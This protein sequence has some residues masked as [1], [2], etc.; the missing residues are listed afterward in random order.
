[1]DPWHMSAAIAPASVYDVAHSTVVSSDP[2]AV[3][4]GGGF[5]TWIVADEALFGAGFGSAVADVTFADATIAEPFA[6]AQSPSN[7]V[8]VNVAVPPGGSEARLHWIG[9]LPPIPGVAPAQPAGAVSDWKAVWGGPA[10]VSD[11]LV[12]GRSSSVGAYEGWFV[13][14]LFVTGL[15]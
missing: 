3:V 5:D 14:A 9:P 15:G 4:T 10:L 12:A 6:A 11:T 7:T 1:M 8:S 13:S 2:L